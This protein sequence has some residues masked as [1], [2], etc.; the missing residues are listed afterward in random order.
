MKVTLQGSSNQEGLKN[1]VESLVAGLGQNPKP[2]SSG[3][4]KEKT[5]DNESAEPPPT[6]TVT[7]RSKSKAEDEENPVLMQVWESYYKQCEG[8]GVTLQ[9]QLLE[10]ANGILFDKMHVLHLKLDPENHT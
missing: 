2:S 5:P 4:E 7:S 10:G 6:P 3:K 8:Q 9:I 1:L